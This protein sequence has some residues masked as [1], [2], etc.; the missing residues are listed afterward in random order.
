MAALGGTAMTKYTKNK[1]A[2][3]KAIRSSSTTASGLI[4][5]Q[6]QPLEVGGPIM[7]EG[8]VTETGL[9]FNAPGNT[10]STIVAR[11]WSNPADAMF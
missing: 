5:Q 7:P 6:D 11:P 3:G 2:A 1:E 10:F 8:F 4:G 9:L